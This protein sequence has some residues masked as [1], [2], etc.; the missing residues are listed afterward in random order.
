[1]PVA[2]DVIRTERLALVDWLET[3]TPE[4]WATP[5]LCE[6]WTV[7]D[8]VSHLAWAPV[9]SPARTVAGLV[10]AGLRLNRFSRDSAVEWSTRGRP[11][12]LAQLRAN[13]LQD[14][15]P[16]GVPRDAVLVDAVVHAVDVRRPLGD[17]RA[18][19]S[20][21]FCA[22]ADYCARTRWPASMMLGG[23][24]ARR[25]AG[26]RLVADDQPWSSGEGPEVH[27]SGETLVLLLCGRGLDPEEL[28]GEGAP[29]VRDRLAAEVAARAGRA[30]RAR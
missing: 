13:A 15:G 17:H 25:V 28:H 5:S 9:L 24:P 6:G 30:G 21:A 27:A 26:V 10:R 16:V 4:Q 18:I 2:W 12:I 8:V 3:L 22:A 20:A 14:V 19:P 11:A 29:V 7:Q 23:G 1:M